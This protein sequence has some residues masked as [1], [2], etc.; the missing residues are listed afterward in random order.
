MWFPSTVTVA[1]TTEPVGLAE[2]RSHLRCDPGVTTDDADIA[3]MISAARAHAEAYCGAVFAEQTIRSD[4]TSFD[5]LVRLPHA[6]LKTVTS[7]AYLDASGDEQ[8][9]AG[10]D[11]E[12]YA[13]D[14]APS[15]VPAYG[16]S[17]P[18][19]RPGSRITLTAV[20]GGICPEAV[21]HAIKLLVG[22][23]YENREE[24]AIGVSVAALPASVSVDA[25]L[26]NHRRFG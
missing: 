7:I 23:W 13:D 26:C 25:L 12:V 6:P 24:T 14:L 21:R 22:A 2:A 10:A 16:T 1:P 17:W 3:A 20:Y 11:Y 18:A 15:I 19:I 4:C 9:L 5:D 8:V